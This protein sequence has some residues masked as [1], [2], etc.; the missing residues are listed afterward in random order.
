[1]YICPR[2]SL[3]S[4]QLPLPTPRTLSSICLLPCVSK[5]VEDVQI[6]FQISE[7]GRT[8]VGVIQTHISAARGLMGGHCLENIY[9]PHL[10]CEHNE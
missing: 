2:R 5:R 10:F 7:T 8:N 4:S 1:M 6:Y 9:L 3:A